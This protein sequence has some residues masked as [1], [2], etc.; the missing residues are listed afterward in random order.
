MGS[1]KI[2]RIDPIRLKANSINKN[3]EDNSTLNI[4]FLLEATGYKSDHG[5]V[6][7]GTNMKI[8]HPIILEGDIFRVAGTI[9]DLEP[10]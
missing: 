4:R 7:E 5:L 8:G 2:L 3:V 6:I 9:S 1:M 10:K